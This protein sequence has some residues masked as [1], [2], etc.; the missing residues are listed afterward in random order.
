MDKKRLEQFRKN[1]EER[2]KALRQSLT[3]VQEDGRVAAEDNAQ[4]I[5][6]KALNSYTKEFLYTKGN[7]DRQLLNLVDKALNRL[8]EGTFGEC[9]HCGEEINSKRLEAVPWT[10]YCIQCQEK[11]ERGQLE[12]RA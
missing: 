9:A 6:D 1:L 2:S 3:R 8:R 4:D 10:L 7:N 5:A 11:K 12:E